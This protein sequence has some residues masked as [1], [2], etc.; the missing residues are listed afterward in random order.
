MSPLRKITKG[1]HLPT[2]D[3][4]LKINEGH[5]LLGVDAWTVI[6]GAGVWVLPLHSGG[7]VK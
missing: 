2:Q 6:R 5:D 7:K 1:G 3:M 4:C